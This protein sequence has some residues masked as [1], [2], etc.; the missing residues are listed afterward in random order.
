M[1]SQSH[2]ANTAGEYTDLASTVAAALVTAGPDTIDQVILQ[3]LA[4]TGRLL[5]VDRCSLF[6]FSQST[7]DLELTHGW[8]ADGVEPLPLKSM[9]AIPAAKLFPGL[10]EVLLAG[11][12]LAVCDTSASDDLPDDDG[13]RLEALGIRSVLLVPMFAGDRGVGLIGVDLVSQPRR[14]TAEE[15]ALLEELGRFM[16]HT[17]LR[18]RAE[19]TIDRL[20]SRYQMLTSRGQSILYEIDREGR[21]SYVSENL[22]SIT[23]YRLKDVIGHSV[24]KILYPDDVSSTVGALKRAL[25][26]QDVVP[27]L[28]YR[29]IY[30]DGSVHWHRSV[31]VPMQ[32]SNGGFQGVVGNA[33]DITDLKQLET[34]LRSEVGLT[35][36]LVRLATEY[37]NLPTE[38]FEPAIERS[39]SELGGFVGADR[40]YVFRYDFSRQIAC[41]THEWCAEGIS[42]QIESLAAV[43]S[44]DIS[45]FVEAHQAGEPLYIPKV[46]RWPHAATRDL[47][48]EQD[49]QS[50]ICVPLMLRGE[51]L[52]FVGFDYVKAERPY[53]EVEIH[54]LTVFAQMLVNM[55]VR[56]H[57]ERD[58]ADERR[59]LEEIVDGTD[60]GTW[61]WDLAAD[62]LAFNDRWA[63]ML[64]VDSTEELPGNSLEWYGWLNK[65]DVAAA[66]DRL[67]EHLKGQS[68]YLEVEIRVRRASGEWLWILARG[69]ISRRDPD[70]R[71]TLMSGIALDIEQRKRDEA[72]L[73][74]AASVFTHS[75]EGILITEPD[76]RIVEVNDSFTRITGYEREEVLGK[77]PN[78][79]A[80]GRHDEAFYRSMW[81]ALIERGAWSGE[82]WNRRRDGTEY[83]Q[84]LTISS[85]RAPDGKPTQYVGLM[86]DITAQKNYQH[87]LE[88]RAHHDALTGL[89]NRVLLG[90]RLSQAMSHAERRK[91][92]IAVVYVDLDNF[93]QINDRCGHHA[94]DEVLRE[95]ARR[96]SQALRETDTVAR[97]GGDEFVAILTGLDPQTHPE[98]SLTRLL[99]IMARP[100]QLEQESVE[101]SLSLGVTLYPQPGQPEAD[102]LLRQADQAM[103]EAKRKG[104]NTVCYFDTELEHKAQQRHSDQR[105]LHQA[106]ADE[107]FVLYYQPQINLRSGEVEGVEALIRW[108]H[109]ERGLLAPG[110]F[111][112]LIADQTLAVELGDWVR[113]QAIRDHQA[114][115]S[116]GLDLDLA[117]NVDAADLLRDDF[118]RR[119]RHL[120]AQHPDFPVRRMLLE[121]VET[122]VLEDLGQ[123]TS[124]AKECSALGVALAL[125]DFGTG[126]SSLSHLKHLPIQQL[127]IDRSFVSDMMDDAD[128]LA[129]VEAV[130][131][132][133][134][135]FRLDVLAEGVETDEQLAAL[136]QL[137]CHQA[138]GYA[139]ARPMPSGELL[140]WIARW[141][142][143]DSWKRIKPLNDDQRL[144][145]FAEVDLRQRFRQLSDMVVHAEQQCSVFAPDQ[146]IGEMPRWLQRF[147]RRCSGAQN[148]RLIEQMISSEQALHQICCTGRQPEAM[149]ELERLD[150]L[151]SRALTE[152]HER[153]IT[154]AGLDAG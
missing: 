118:A 28:E 149:A 36:L 101:I 141:Q 134:R 31:L 50:V 112:P 38:D 21:Y 107:E 75:G 56:R 5:A 97:P 150:G 152:L 125:D 111:L 51:C 131:N 142:A 61:E 12:E 81:A 57:I 14:W 104:R 15:S 116:A 78:M 30:A 47:L 68:G 1:K 110:A 74:K 69:R 130:I 58:L 99:E 135:V 105:R 71:A 137:G 132:L 13:R 83:A 63:A 124:M 138:Q 143:P 108:A 121:V 4:D 40:A 100:I 154:A 59:R 18:V 37:I 67:I 3:A 153:R 79:L 77:N 86:T 17:L 123:A 29:V 19:Q 72:D 139:F 145:L 151:I 80:S 144:S 43:P 76:G 48:A 33:L 90:D 44:A 126:F 133:G 9:S 96:L 115:R 85:V 8:E 55:R 119:L 62:H 117:V 147:E 92:S 49:I 24:S 103:F 39:L 27:T 129:I 60:A 82:L 32:D 52:G 94:G 23:G 26:D 120:L 35:E 122:S 34:N 65:H 140:E 127:K 54:L 91:Q 42:P 20:T 70:G 128:D 113:L 102:Q 109:P 114:W 53:S 146:R 136:I 93:K 88:H 46:S 66:R 95:V 84:L 10:M 73:Q 98:G 2:T 148:K 25:T 41:N 16:T 6:L 7:S 45:D 22:E 64:G 89:P 106:L 11:V 87:E